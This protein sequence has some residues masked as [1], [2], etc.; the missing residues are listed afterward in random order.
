MRILAI[1][2][3]IINQFRR[4]KRTLALMFLAPL[5]LI[6]L[7]TYLFEGDTVKPVVGVA[8]ISDSMVK[9]LKANDLTIKNYSTD[10]N[11]NDKIKTADLD[12]FFLQNG[13]KIEVTYENS[14]PSV[15]KEIGLKLQKALMQEQQEQVKSQAKVTGEA[16]AKAGVDPNSISSLSN[17]AEK[18]TVSTNYVYGD[19]DTNFFDTISPI[20]IGFFVFFFVFLIAG[21]SF[22]RERTTGTLERLMATPIKRIELELGYLIGFGIFAL[23]QSILVAVFSIQVLDMMQNGSLFHVLLITLTLGLVSLALGILLSTFA[24]NEFQIV[25]FIPIVIVPQIL[26]CGIFPLDGMADWLV[27]IAHIMPLYYGANALTAIMVK[28]EGFASFATDFYILVG[29]VVLFVVL[30][31]FALKKYRKV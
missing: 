17:G 20:F 24:N 3:R 28:G 14:E 9:E 18:L 25:Q 1:V 7:L 22:L 26:F 21:I 19:K 6:T 15:S 8:G 5:L 30:N 27:W 16:L 10:I 13:E 4:D 31:I 29:F 12:A 23:L 2:K 11:V